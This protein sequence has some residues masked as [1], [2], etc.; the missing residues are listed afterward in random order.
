M[1]D[2]L[3]VTLLCA[4]IVLISASWRSEYPLLLDVLGG[5]CA[6]LY[7]SRTKNNGE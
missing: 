5:A 4:A 3:N 1:K 6:G 2:L 7:Y